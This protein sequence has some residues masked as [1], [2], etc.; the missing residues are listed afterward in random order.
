MDG[1]SSIAARIQ[2][3][4]VRTL[5]PS[6]LSLQTISS[7]TG[8]R[9]KAE[10]AAALIAPVAV[11]WLTDASP[12]LA[13]TIASRGQGIG[14]RSLA[15][16]PIANARPTARGRRGAIVEGCGVIVSERLPTTLA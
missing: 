14:A 8:S 13:T 12:R 11:E 9:W 5:M 15:P 6:P 1:R 10:K 3:G 16:R 4:G 2:P 7:G